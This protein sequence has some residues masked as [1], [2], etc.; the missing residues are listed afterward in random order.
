LEPTKKSSTYF[1][2][3]VSGFFVVSASFRRKS[4]NACDGTFFTT[5]LAALH[6]VLFLPHGDK[7]TTGSLIKGDCADA[8]TMKRQSSHAHTTFDAWSNAR[9]EAQL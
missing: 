7:E 9:A 6:V 8:S 3:Y 4:Q 5:P 1:S 2:G